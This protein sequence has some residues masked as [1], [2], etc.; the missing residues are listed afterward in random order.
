MHSTPCAYGCIVSYYRLILRSNDERAGMCPNGIRCPG[1]NNEID[2]ESWDTI[3]DPWLDSRLPQSMLMLRMLHTNYC[4][5]DADALHKVF[6][7]AGT[8][9]VVQSLHGLRNDRPAV[10]M[11]AARSL[12]YT[13]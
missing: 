2:R 9:K 7:Y 3:F 8:S 4:S 12:H 5:Y 6:L 1:Y 13:M 10:R 11:L